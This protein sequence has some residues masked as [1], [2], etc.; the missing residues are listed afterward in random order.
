MEKNA[1][2]HFRKHC[3]FLKKQQD[4]VKKPINLGSSDL[5]CF[6]L[7]LDALLDLAKL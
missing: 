4:T 5:L 6:F 3:I 7:D 1:Y 2:G